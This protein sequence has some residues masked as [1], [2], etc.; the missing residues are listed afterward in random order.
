MQAWRWLT[1]TPGA[2]LAVG[3]GVVAWL[4]LLAQLI[5]FAIEQPIYSPVD[6]FNHYFYIQH[7]YYLHRPPAAG[8]VFQVTTDP[9]VPPA[10]AIPPSRGSGVPMA[11]LYASTEGIQPPGYY[12]L[13]A[14]IY[15]LTQHG[16]YAQIIAIRLAT[17][18]LAALIVPL[19]FLLARVA[20]P[21]AP[22]V[23]AAAT[24]LTTLSRG[25]SFN[26]SQITNDS[27]AVVV[28]G[29]GIL[30]FLWLLRSRIDWRWGLV[31]GSVA[32]I[33]IFTKVTVYYV[34]I[35]L[36]GLFAFRVIQARRDGSDIC[37]SRQTCGRGCSIDQRN[38]V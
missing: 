25:Y 21:A 9:H 20:L 22:W 38:A 18:A 30:A 26:L 17:A 37:C 35:A 36:A 10:F 6:E 19:T 16:T 31:A 24:W 5:F 3:V 33:A 15:G 8:V 23:W 7:L 32:G 29:I 1:A 12:L 28:G 14:P 13:M 2:R 34:P 11:H 27:L 4:F